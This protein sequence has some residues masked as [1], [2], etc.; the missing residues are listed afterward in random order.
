MDGLGPWSE[1]LRDTCENYGGVCPPNSLVDLTCFTCG[2]GSVTPPPLVSALSSK[3]QHSA[4]KRG[5]GTPWVQGYTAQHRPW[6][7]G[8]VTARPSGWGGQ[9]STL[10]CVL[11]LHPAPTWPHSSPHIGGQSHSLHIACGVFLA[12]RV[13]GRSRQKAPSL[14]VF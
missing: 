10:L 3:R 1:V 4:D 9:G 2:R 7:E 13:S 12:T 6:E 11:C 8:A 14:T 5:W